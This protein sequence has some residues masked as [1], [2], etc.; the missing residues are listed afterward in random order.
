[1]KSKKPSRYF[2]L[3]SPD[4]C[5]GGYHII[6]FKSCKTPDDYMEKFETIFREITEQEPFKDC[7]VDYS[8]IKSIYNY[9]DWNSLINSQINL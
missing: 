1:M 4:K 5:Y 2:E 7:F 6:S 3:I 9:V 8:S